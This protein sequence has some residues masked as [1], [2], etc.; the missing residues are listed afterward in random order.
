MSAYVFIFKKLNLN[1][2]R[3]RL[4]INILVLKVFV[5]WVYVMYVTFLN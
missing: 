1:S 2:E 4:Q 5:S 3:W